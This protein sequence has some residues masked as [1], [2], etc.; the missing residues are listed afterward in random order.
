M[1]RQGCLEKLACSQSTFQK[2]MKHYSPFKHKKKIDTLESAMWFWGKQREKYQSVSNPFM[3]RNG[4]ILLLAI[5]LLNSSWKSKKTCILTTT[6]KFLSTYCIYISITENW[7]MILKLS[8]SIHVHVTT[9]DFEQWISTQ[10][11]ITQTRIL[12]IFY[13]ILSKIL[14]QATLQLTA[15]KNHSPLSCFEY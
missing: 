2:I 9:D 4:Y 7:F 6:L 12:R 11:V 3:Y 8:I 1:K 15:L 14:N 13:Y 10:Q 5:W